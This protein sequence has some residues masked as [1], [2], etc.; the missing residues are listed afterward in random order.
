MSLRIVLQ[1]QVSCLS[2]AHEQIDHA[3]AMAL[4][5]R[6]PVYINVCCNIAGGSRLSDVWGP[7]LEANARTLFLV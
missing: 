4:R 5:Q 3:I 2:D 6:L 1:V 7:H